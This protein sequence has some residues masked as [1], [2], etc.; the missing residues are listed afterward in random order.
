MHFIQLCSD[1]DKVDKGGT[2]DYDGISLLCN[3]RNCNMVYLKHIVLAWSQLGI[4]DEHLHAVL[5]RE[6]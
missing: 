4:S 3:L 1:D 6:F 5:G 2:L